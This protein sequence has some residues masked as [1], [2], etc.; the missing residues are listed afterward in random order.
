MSGRGPVLAIAVGALALRLAIAPIPSFWVDEAFTIALV[1]GSFGGTLDGLTETESTPPLYYAV[2]WAW[3]QA[4]GLGE[5]GLRSL[6]ALAGAVTVAIVFALA[7]RGAGT[8]RAGVAAGALAAVNPF[9]V[10]FSTEA[11]AYALATALATGALLALLVALDRREDRRPLAAWALLAALALLA[12][13]A[14]VFVLLPQ[15]ALLLWRQRTGAAALATAAVV[16]VG[17]ALIPL[18]VAQRGNEHA[19]DVGEFGGSVLKRTAQVPKQFASGYDAPAELALAGVA[20][21]VLAAG[22]VAALLAAPPVRRWTITLL[23]IV[24]ASLA[25]PLAAAI[26]GIVDLMAARYVLPA[27]PPLLAVAGAGLVAGPY[28]RAGAALA[29][30][31]AVLWLAAVIAIAADPLLQTRAQWSGVDDALGPAPPGGR[32]IVTTPATG[33]FVLRTA[34]RQDA[35]EEPTGPVQEVALTAAVSRGDDLPAPSP[36]APPPAPPRFAAAG[37]DLVEE[38]VERGFTVQRWRASAPLELDPATL[39]AP[40]LDPARPAAILWEP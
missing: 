18:A 37:F 7:R 3:T 19:Q 6:S 25:L 17:L 21:L 38:R 14:T 26:A 15:A 29:A 40:H 34:Y 13:Y 23:A 39:T 1:D 31:L 4:A 32:A 28:R 10:W 20:L 9:L 24:A 27:L 22:V 8:T 36:I 35:L 2:A 33:A 12:H 11:R 30:A 5:L 16:A